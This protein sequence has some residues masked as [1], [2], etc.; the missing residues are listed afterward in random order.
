MRW[1][2]EG[3]VFENISIYLHLLKHIFIQSA[4]LSSIIQKQQLED[5]KRNKLAEQRRQ[6]PAPIVKGDYYDSEQYDRRRQALND[7]QHK[8]YQNYLKNVSVW[9]LTLTLTPCI[10]WFLAHSCYRSEGEFCESWYDHL[11]W[12]SELSWT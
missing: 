12:W 1:F 5:D 10:L 3:S 2:V 11:V 8:E 9:R 4:F 7:L 6:A